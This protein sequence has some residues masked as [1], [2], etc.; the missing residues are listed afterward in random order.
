MTKDTHD[1]M[2]LAMTKNE[3]SLGKMVNGKQGTMTSEDLQVLLGINENEW[4]AR[5]MKFM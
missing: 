4:C 3:H 1:Y 5:Y 2:E